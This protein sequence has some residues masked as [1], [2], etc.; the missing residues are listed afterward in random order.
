MVK[1]GYAE[2]I[3]FSNRLKTATATYSDDDICRY[4]NSMYSS[5]VPQRPA[6]RLYPTPTQTRRSSPEV[7]KGNRL[8]LTPTLGREHGHK[9]ADNKLLGA[10]LK[11][12]SSEKLSISSEFL[13]VDR[14]YINICRSQSTCTIVTTASIGIE[15]EATPQAFVP[16]GVW[17]RCHVD[18]LHISQELKV[19]VMRG[20]NCMPDAVKKTGK[21]TAK[22]VLHPGKLQSKKVAVGHL[23]S[24]KQKTR[25]AHF[26]GLAL[27]CKQLILSVLVYTSS[28]FFKKGRVVGE[29][30]VPLNQLRSGSNVF[31]MKYD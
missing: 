19:D 1:K 28:T 15:T 2:N 7:K 17:F 27:P 26:K 11:P 10:D 8:T 31:W 21:L 23:H 22:I 16:E 6:K 12:K 4:L 24:N 18:Y 9:I 14:F 25:S 5:P 3:R 20:G 29:W 13:A 30:L